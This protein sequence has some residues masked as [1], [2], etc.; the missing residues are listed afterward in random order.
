TIEDNGVGRLQAAAYNNR[1][2][3]YHKSVGLKITE[4]R[5]HIFNGLQSNENDVVITDLYDE[6]RQASGTRV[7]IKI[8]IL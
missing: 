6:K 7:S 4:N 5:V 3:P 2:K 1:N 8:K